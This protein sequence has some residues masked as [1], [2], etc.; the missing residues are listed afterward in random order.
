MP[1]MTT[2]MMMTMTAT[3]T[4]ATATSKATK[5]T[6]SEVCKNKPNTVS[7]ESNKE[8]KPKM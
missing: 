6:N 5:S 3:M 1:A 8:L 7:M 4:V 2:T